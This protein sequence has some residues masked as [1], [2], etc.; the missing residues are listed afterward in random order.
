M[1]LIHLFYFI[2]IVLFWSCSDEKPITHSEEYEA[3]LSVTKTSQY[4]IQDDINFWSDRLMRMPNDEASKIK[5]AGLL[6]ANFRKTGKIEMLQYSDSLYHHLL[7]TTTSTKAG[8]Y[9]GLAQNSI[10]QHQFK[11]A[12]GYAEQALIEGGREAASLLVI[13]DVALELNNIQEAKKTLQRFT[14]KNSFAHLVRQS[15]LQDHEGSLESAIL[16]VEKGFNRIKGNKDLYCWTLSNL[17]DMYGHAG[18]IADAYRA[19]L[20]V[21]QKDPEYDYALK[22]IAWIALSH[23]KNYSEAK[24]IISV[25]ASRSRMPEAHLMLAEIAELQQDEQEKIKQLKSFVALTDIPGY[26]N[27]YAKYLADLYAEDLNEPEKSLAIAEEEITNRPTPQSF[28]LKA[29]ALLQLGRKQE[30]FAIAKKYVV[31]KTFE[32]ETAY[33]LGVIYQ[34]NNFQDEA[35]TYLEEALKS[36]FELGPC[37]TVKIQN[38]LQK[39]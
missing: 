29:W 7:E 12:Q 18:R 36:S 16:T 4:S 37:T 6:A 11:R 28:D 27:M 34:A 15:K 30:A 21:L 33:H 35:E 26:K 32:P 31:G 17:G 2:T 19:Y 24:R 25:L 3:Y 14:N 8:L 9:L 1:K 39:I 13:T 38:A 20:S 5:V 22:G 23:D 10:T